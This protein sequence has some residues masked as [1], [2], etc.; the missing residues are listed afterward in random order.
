MSAVLLE[1]CALDKLTFLVSKL[2]LHLLR[3]LTRPRSY[4]HV[5]LRL[6]ANG[7]MLAWRRDLGRVS[8]A[9]NKPIGNDTCS[10]GVDRLVQQVDPLL[11][12]RPSPG[13]RANTGDILQRLIVEQA[14]IH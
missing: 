11:V 1:F 4:F 10:E 8:R 13:W 2:G 6:D 14:Q 12:D 7:A 3:Q 5:R 9:S